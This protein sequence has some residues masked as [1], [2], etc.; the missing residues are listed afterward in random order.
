MPAIDYIAR[1][2]GFEQDY[3]EAEEQR[4]ALKTYTDRFA[5]IAMALDER[6]GDRKQLLNEFDTCATLYY[7]DKI[8][9]RFGS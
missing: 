4:K 1:A 8:A 7:R 2:E 3:R 5:S 9:G 6:P